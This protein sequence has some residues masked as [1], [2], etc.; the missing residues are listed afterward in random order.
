MITHLGTPMQVEPGRGGRGS[1][2]QSCDPQ[3]RLPMTVL[4]GGVGFLSPPV[5]PWCH[6]LLPT[7]SDTVH[8]LPVTSAAVRTPTPKCQG[9]L[10]ETHNA[11]R[12]SSHFPEIYRAN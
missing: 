10:L 5:L 1:P 11:K 8:T 12:E 3:G 2:R 6:V 7:L 4:L 9:D